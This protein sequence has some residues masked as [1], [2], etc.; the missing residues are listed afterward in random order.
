MRGSTFALLG[1]EFL[2]RVDLGCELPQ[3]GFSSRSGQLSGVVSG[4]ES[5]R[6]NATPVAKFGRIDL[7]R[8]GN[9]DRTF[10]G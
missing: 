3:E 4:V 1:R 6:S 10:R 5:M 2:V 7:K 9:N 8:V